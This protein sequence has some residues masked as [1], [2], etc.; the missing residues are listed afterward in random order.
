MKLA[1][2]LVGLVACSGALAA[3]V[4]LGPHHRSRALQAAYGC[5]Y[6][7]SDMVDCSCKEDPCEMQMK[8]GD[9]CKC[10]GRCVVDSL[11]SQNCGRF[12]SRLVPGTNRRDPRAAN[13]ECFIEDDAPEPAPAPAPR[14]SRGQP[15][16]APTISSSQ[17]VSVVQQ[18]AP[19]PVIVQ[20]PVP[21][22][23]P[24]PTPVPAPPV[25]APPPDGGRRRWWSWW[26]R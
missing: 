2:L 20:V 24:V 17:S 12:S 23:V 1:V 26:G 9:V 25:A 7:V 18:A 6:G 3:R 5:F 19:A 22:P 13:C 21:V 15:D 11:Y 10:V 16:P 14:R 8:N 4:D